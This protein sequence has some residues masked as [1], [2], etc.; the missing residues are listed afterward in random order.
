MDRGRECDPPRLPRRD[1]PDPA[2]SPH[3]AR[4]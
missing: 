1:F 2:P 4:S 3:N